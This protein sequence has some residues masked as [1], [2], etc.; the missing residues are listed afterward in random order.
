MY[1]AWGTSSSDMYEENDEDIALM[2]IEESDVEHEPDSEETEV[3]F[4]NLKDKLV[5]FSKKKLSFLLLASINKIQELVNTKIQLLASLSSLKFE[6]IGLNKNKHDLEGK[7]KQ[8]EFHNQELR[9][10]NLKLKVLGKENGGELSYQKL[11]VDKLKDNLKLEKENSRRINLE[12]TRIRS[13]LERANK[14]KKSSMILTH[15]ATQTDVP[16]AKKSGKFSTVNFKGWQQRVDFL[17]KRDILSS[18]DD[19]L[20]NIYSKKI[21]L[22]ELW[23]ALKKKYKTK[24]ACLEKIVIRKSLDYKMSDS[25]TIG[26]QE[27]EFQLIFYD[28][29]VETKI[30]NGDFQVATMIKKLPP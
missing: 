3:N 1:P 25:K 27:L 12:L 15:L 8:L 21:T 16:P 23:N 30:V 22:K 11:E 18:F 29:L 4:L 10:E 7:I 13:Y 28:L 17:W 14:W 26:S 20:Y 5:K 9:T 24:D 6:H 19:D 2:A